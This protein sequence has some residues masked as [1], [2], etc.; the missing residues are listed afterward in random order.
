MPPGSGLE[1]GGPTSM[2]VELTTAPSTA[3]LPIEGS[4]SI[5]RATRSASVASTP[6]PRPARV[7]ALLMA[8]VDWLT[9]ILIIAV[10]FDVQTLRFFQSPVR[11]VQ[12][13]VVGGLVELSTQL[14][15]GWKYLPAYF[16]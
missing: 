5:Q 1:P 8:P 10:P 4:P 13:M 15:A 16:P 11:S 2:G 12:V 14:S 7:E 6:R 3:G 9:S